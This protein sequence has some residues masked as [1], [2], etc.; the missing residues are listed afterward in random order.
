MKIYKTEKVFEYVEPVMLQK[1]ANLELYFLIA[2][3][4]ALDA[5]DPMGQ[6]SVRSYWEAYISC[7]F[8]SGVGSGI[9]LLIEVCKFS[10]GSKTL[11]S[12]RSS[13]F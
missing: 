7:L 1:G 10:T 6:W 13:A 11:L 2:I 3:A 12:L 9:P 4:L 8:L 5:Q